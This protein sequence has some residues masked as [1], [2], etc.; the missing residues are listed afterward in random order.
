VISNARGLTRTYDGARSLAAGG[1]PG[2]PTPSRRLTK[3][4]IQSRVQL[5]NHL[6]KQTELTG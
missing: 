5:A 6:H 1:L 4:N 3:L 2:T